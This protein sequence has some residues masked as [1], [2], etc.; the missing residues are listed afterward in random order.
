MDRRRGWTGKVAFCCLAGFACSSA[1]QA[2]TETGTTSSFG[3]GLSYIPQTT[4]AGSSL[5]P[6]GLAVVP[7]PM[8]SATQGTAGTAYPRAADPLGL[9]FVYGST[10]IPMTPG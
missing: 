9:G 6:S 2:P 7:M 8:L 5:G 3:L 10:A 4:S 1:S